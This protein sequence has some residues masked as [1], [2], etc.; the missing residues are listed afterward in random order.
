MQNVILAYNNW[1]MPT[2][3]VTPAVTV[4]VGAGWIDTALLTGRVLSEMARCPSVDLADTQ[5]VWDMGTT[6]A[7]RVLGMPMHNC[8]IG[9]RVRVRL[10]TDAAITDVTLDTGWQDVIGEWYPFGSLPWGD[11]RSWD[12]LP[13][14]EDLA[15]YAPP[16]LHVA[17]ADAYGRYVKWE[18]DIGTN[19]AGYLDV[20][21]LFVGSAIQ[22][23]YNYSYGIKFAIVDKSPSA[24]SRGGAVFSD[25]I[26]QYRTVSFQLDW[27]S[28][29][30]AFG[31]V[32]E[33]QRRVGTTEP[34]LFIA[35]PD[36]GPAL[37]TKRAMVATLADLSPIDHPSF[38]AHSV[39]IRLEEMK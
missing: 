14:A 25:A 9:D 35:D 26:E 37:L 33:M 22:P 18:W 21:R 28:R 36:D 16:W 34:I 10:A 39:Q 38:G 2:V 20:G 4:P 24:R 17:A 31:Q 29:E 7:V 8:S 30:E 23:R 19:P 12:G 32:F 15:G 13:T 3:S 27:L 5:M 6:R 1:L 11:P